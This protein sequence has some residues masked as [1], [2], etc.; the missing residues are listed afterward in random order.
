MSILDIHQTT[1]FDEAICQ[2]E[3]C[4][5]KRTDHKR[6]LDF[7]NEPCTACNCPSFQ[8]LSTNYLNQLSFNVNSTVLNQQIEQLEKELD[9]SIK[10][11]GSLKKKLKDEKTKNEELQRVVTELRLDLE[12]ANHVKRNLKSLLDE[13]E[14]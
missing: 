12:I 10:E 5:H 2:N 8:L 11:I 9:A 1:F 7:H 14:K 3:S 6:G 4:R 13:K